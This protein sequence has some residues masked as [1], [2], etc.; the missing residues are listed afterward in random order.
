MVYLTRIEYFTAAH[1]LYNTNWTKEKNEEVFGGC[2]NENW[3]GHNFDLHVTVKGIP[4]KDTGFV[5]DA[6]VLGQIIK[7]HIIAKV[8]HKNL[9]LDVDF[10]KDT[11]CTV[12]NLAIG[13]WNELL[14]HLP[15]EASLHCIRIYETQRIYVEYFGN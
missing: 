3:H 4:Q 15:E 9:N 1:K 14:P 13:I 5:M 10:M 12:E 2:A 6:K 7:E 8:D 11:M